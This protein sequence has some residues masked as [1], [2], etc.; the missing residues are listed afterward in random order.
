MTACARLPDSIKLRSPSSAKAAALSSPMAMPYLVSSPALARHPSAHLLIIRH[1]ALAVLLRTA[2]AR[3]IDALSSQAA[4]SSCSFTRTSDCRVGGTVRI[5]DQLSR[6]AAIIYMARSSRTA[7]SSLIC[8]ASMTGRLSAVDRAGV[9]RVRWAQE[10]L[11]PQ[12]GAGRFATAS[13]P[14]CWSCCGA[15][16]G[17]PRAGCRQTGPAS[18]AQ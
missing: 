11:A 1:P 16:L 12:L 4:W 6:A 2:V 9:R 14:A 13:L 17:Q 7:A 5:A 8:D 18:C 15:A 10:H 3:R